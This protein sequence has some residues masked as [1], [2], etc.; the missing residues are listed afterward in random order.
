MCDLP[1]HTINSYVRRQYYNWVH[2][3][4][5]LN[6]IGLKMLKNQNKYLLPVHSC[7]PLWIELRQTRTFL[8]VSNIMLNP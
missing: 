4:G 6:E 3:V 1:L 5:F 2:M 7:C 8:F